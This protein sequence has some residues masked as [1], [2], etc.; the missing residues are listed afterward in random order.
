MRRLAAEHRIALEN[1]AE[2]DNLDSG[3]R[4]TQAGDDP[5]ALEK[6]NESTST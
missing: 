5:F 1:T 2:V 3:Y 6:G 4:R